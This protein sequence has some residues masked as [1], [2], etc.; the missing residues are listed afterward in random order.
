MSGRAG[1]YFRSSGRDNVTPAWRSDCNAE[2]SE[3][4]PSEPAR[5][6]AA[7]AGEIIQGYKG[8]PVGNRINL[9]VLRL[10]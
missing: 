6:A 9:K 2:Q 1:T 3:P 7:G 4:G 5:K 8:L 10:N